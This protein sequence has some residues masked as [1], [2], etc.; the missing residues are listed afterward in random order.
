MLAGRK[1]SVKGIVFTEFLEMV[2]AQYSPA[3]VEDL[4]DQSD[5]PSKGAYT[6]VG[7][8]PHCEMIQLV[9]GL[10]KKTSIAVPSLMKAYGEHLFER[11]HLRYPQFFEEEMTSF[12]FLAKV[13][14]HI[15]L[16]VKKLYPDAKLPSF[17]IEKNC[18]SHFSMIYRS[19]RP[20]SDLCE[21]LIIGCIK[22][23]GEDA[24]LTREDLP[25]ENLTQVRFEIVKDCG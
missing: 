12:D 25:S 19:E 9:D 3:F 24:T 23:F 14:N 20:F 17:I 2:E 4:I 15:H 7:T 21:G 10:S 18:A 8:Y 5:L 6:A 11:F 22:H 13:E 1:H 16:E